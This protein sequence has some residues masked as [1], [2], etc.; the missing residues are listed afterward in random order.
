VRNAWLLL[1]VLTAALIGW[2]FAP[3]LTGAASFAFRDAAHFYHPLFQYIRGEWGA[4]RV[5]LWNPYEN[6]GVPLVA[7]NTSSVFYPGKL[8]FALPLDY[9]WLYNMYIVG[10]VALASATSYRLARHLRASVPGAVLGAL[11]YAFSGCVL[12][13]YCNVIFLVGAAWLPLALLYADRLLRMRE[14]WAALGFGVVVALIV[15][16]GDPHLAYN[17]GLVSVGYA[18]LLWW[19]DRRVWR[20]MT[21]AGGDAEIAARLKPDLVPWRLVYLVMGTVVASLIAAVQVLPSLEA[22]SFGERSHY[23]APRN[24]Y[25][26]AYQLSTSEESVPYERLL[27]VPSLGHHSHVYAFSLAPWRAI[28]MI[29]PNV[30]G[31]L[32]PTHRRWLLALGAE[33]TLWLPSLY[34]GLLPLALAIGA[35]SLKRRAP[36]ETRGLSWLALLAALASLGS[37]GIG[38]LLRSILGA[39]DLAVGDEVGGV[40]WWFVTLLPGYV[41]FR[42]PVKLFV[43]TSLALSM[44]AARGWRTAWTS[45]RNVFYLLAAVPVLSLIAFLALSFAW[46]TWQGQL[47]GWATANYQG[48]FDWD[49]AWNDS[50]DGLIHASLLAFVLAGLLWIARRSPRD[51]RVLQ[52]AALA[53][54]AIDLAAAQQHL[55]DFAPAA[56][57]SKPI[58]F[59]AR[60]PDFA[61]RVY[62]QASLIPPSFEKTRSEHR[63]ADAVSLERETLSPKY[64][65]PLHIRAM[66]VAQSVA[67]ADFEQLIDAARLYTRRRTRHNVPD[68]AVLDMLNV[69]VCII[70]ERDH[71]LLDQA[72]PIAEGI[73]LG[74]RPSAMPRAWIVHQVE[75]R[76]PFESRLERAT[77][78]YT[79]E[80]LFPDNEPRD[81]RKVAVVETAEAVSLPAA[82][83]APAASGESCEIER[84]EPLVVEIRARLTAPGLVVLADQFFPGW[85][86]TVETAGQSRGQP[87]LRTNRIL[88]GAVLPPGEHRLI[89]R[90]RPRSFYAGA[91]VSVL[92]CLGVAFAIGVHWRR[93]RS[94]QSPAKG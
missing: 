62:R 42:Y 28:E 31:R 5:P 82:E 58:E 73:F 11:S 54:T 69:Q 14:P 27:K 24:V 61:A 34:I 22:S 35:F 45:N 92:T 49:G 6:L 66:P 18:M 67:G 17:L 9:T 52:V 64:P 37:Y 80:L 38:Y 68:A 91:T 74:E 19:N 78:E 76:P 50:L 94:A 20:A 10:H 83:V 16:G 87:I 26:Y 1:L 84:D 71:D 72:Q 2:L 88:R 36:I 25:E 55:L 46:H 56:L 23:D 48:P 41:Q 13:Q 51:R 60:H 90:Y 63:Y 7:E 65:L 44:L 81:W 15:L 57:W 59:A 86:L 30:T 70:G 4:G 33:D 29:W 43:L 53:V 40:Y 47:I 12:F 8:L 3:A 85:E 79:R 89:Y 39:D 21:A 93:K 32:V 75:V 77:R